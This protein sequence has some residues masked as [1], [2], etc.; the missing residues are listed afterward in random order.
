[1]KKK[2]LM[3]AITLILSLSTVTTAEMIIT[4]ATGRGADGGVSND[5]NLRSTVVING[6]D[7]PIRHFDGTRAK[8]AILRFDV[9]AVGGDI[10]GVT[11][12]Y[13]TTTANRGRTIGIYYMTDDSLDMWN[14]ATISYRTAPG[15]LPSGPLDN[16]YDGYD[17][18]ILTMDQTKWVSA[19][20]IPVASAPALNTG[21][22]DPN[23]VANDKNG[24]ITLLLYNE[25][26]DSGA[27]YYI[28]NKERV[29][30]G[31]PTL[32]FPNARCAINPVPAFDA[33]VLP[34][35]TT[36]SWT[37]T[38]PNH[39]SGTFTCDVY[40]GTNEPNLAKPGYNL[41]QIASGIAATSVTIPESMRPLAETRYYWIVDSYDSSTVPPALGTGAVW[42]F[43][44][45]AVPV[46]TAHPQP[47]VVVLG[48]T[49]E[50]SVTV[51]SY[52][53]AH[54]TW[55]RSTDNVNN[56][57]ADDVQVG[58]DSSTLSWV[59]TQTDDGYYYCKVVNNSG[60]ANAVYSNTASLVVRRQVA[61]WTLDQADFVGGQ[62]LD[63]SGNG[64]H[65][66]PNT[67]TPTFAAGVI[68]GSDG[69]SMG[70][71]SFASAG[72]WNPS[73]ISGQLTIAMWIKWNGTNGSYQNLVSKMDTWAADDMMWQFGVS[74]NG[75]VN[76]IRAGG[77]NISNGVPVVGQWEFLA[78]TFNGTTATVYR[79]VDGN[80]YFTT[81]AG[82]FSFGT[83]TAATLWLGSS[84]FNGTIDD[85]Q[86]FNYSKD[87]VALADL[88]NEMLSRDFCVL[89]YG[90][91]EF[92][93]DVNNNCRIELTDFAALA[94]NWMGCGFHPETACP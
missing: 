28:A 57:A 81:V 52:S 86:I 77:A 43:N 85:I 34:S 22:F 6:S 17:N 60:E 33:D 19:G 59:T 15:L 1:M 61:H 20:T 66:D 16:G 72:T 41:T 70:P 80:I 27:S 11:L 90:S 67:A 50:F 24:L 40:L 87:P 31:W 69:V 79:V 64:H 78:M 7:A 30:G 2:W 88:Y 29:A 56:T 83:D 73:Y 18:A 5:D 3:I 37:N 36:L 75:T 12:S 82:A 44:V 35:L 48:E 14:E 92:D 65:A 89:T 76:L 45:T 94:A 93:L 39:P 8:A 84:L 42:Y 46:I 38:E 26:S 23:I 63:V 74:I 62:Y 10:S 47:Q 91:A 55:Y 51:D 54:Y 68:T 25:P 21:P 53:P 13:T 9:R 49:A 32:T 58:T 4:T 71:L